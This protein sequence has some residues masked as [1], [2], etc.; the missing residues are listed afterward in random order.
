[1]K[2]LV[3]GANGFVGKNLCSV[4]NNIKNQKDPSNY[5]IKIDDI[6]EVDIDSK[7]EDIENYCKHADFVYHLAGVNRPNN[8][9]EFMQGNYMLSL[10]LLNMLIKYNNKAPIML[11]SSIQ[12]TL[13]G[14]FFD[15]EYGKSKKAGEDLFIEY[16]QKTKVKIFIYRFTNLFG[17][18]CKPNYN[19]VVATFCNNIA[20]G[21]PITVDD[22]NTELEL[23]YI[24]DVMKEMVGLLNFKEHRCDYL[25]IEAI[26]HKHGK[27]C[28]V[29][30][31]YKV[32]L[33]QIVELLEKFYLHSKILKMSEIPADSF[34][35]K[36]YS[37]YLSYL[38]QE[39]IKVSLNMHKDDR[40]SF[41]E[42]LKTDN[43]GQFSVNIIKPNITKGEHWHHSKWELFIVV[44]GEALIQQRKINTD[45]ILECNVSGEKIEMIHILPGYTHN[46]TNL[47]NKNDLIV[48]M[49]ANEEFD[50]QNPDTFYEKVN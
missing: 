32:K 45:K 34:E 14:K 46:I 39:K 33:Y 17:K 24:D 12:A 43:C 5:H 47:S 9:D 10:E 1:M 31:S 44:S 49:W 37:T 35:K 15:S 7:K 2:I 30:L 19:S 8:S 48:F 20:N 36:L 29:P 41:T 18:W 42:V 28:Y 26:P 11:A 3:T 6:F 27:Y 25:G 13:D 38:P 16:E 21:I 4:L 40:G 50:M 23:T 22:N